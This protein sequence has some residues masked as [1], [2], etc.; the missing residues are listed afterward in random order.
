M[1]RRAEGFTVVELLVVVAVMGILLA[2]VIPNLTRYLPAHRLG[3]GIN[4][5]IGD[6]RLTRQ[7]AIAEGNDFV[8]KYPV[9]S[10]SSRYSVHNND[11]SDRPPQIDS[12]EELLALRLP[13]QVY[14]VGTKTFTFKSD[15]TVIDI[16][17]NPVSAFNISLRNP[18]GEQDSLSVLPSGM[19]MK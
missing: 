15:G 8:V 18:R 13:S 3:M 1:L 19:V 4:Q 16:N 2:I 12:G 17:G 9:D 10:D 14:F 11:D 7:K 6:L 5:V